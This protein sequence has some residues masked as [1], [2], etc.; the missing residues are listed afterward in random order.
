MI[1]EPFVLTAGA[2]TVD[3]LVRDI[4]VCL[5]AAGAL[6][7]LCA[8]LRLPT[9]AA[10]LLAGVAIGPVGL[11]IVTDQARIETI[12]R[13]GLVLLLFVIGVEVDLRMFA[14][15]GRAILISGLLQVPLTVAA[16]WGAFLGLRALGVP[17]LAGG[18]APLY[19]ALAC[20]FSSTLLVFQLLHARKQLDAGSSQLAIALL[21]FQ[22]AWAIVVLAV[23][24][25][26][27]R[28]DLLPILGTFAGIFLLVVAA[29]GASKWVLPPLF[30]LVAKVP[31][32][33]VLTALSWCFA[34]GLF[35]TNLDPLLSLVG[36]HA[37]LSV[38]LE[39]AALIAGAS[40]GGLPYAHEIVGK[41]ISLRDFFVTL[42]F[43]AIGM[44]IPLPRAPEVIGLAC[45]L[46]VIAVALRALVFLPVLHLAGVDRRRAVITATRLAQLSE[47]C[48]VILYLGR[49]LGHVDGDLV[50]VV[51]L[52]FV[53][54]ALATQP[55]FG[56]AERIEPAL[57]P[58]LSRL[59]MPAPNES[60]DTPM[61]WAPTRLLLLGF[62]RLSS[63]II[64]DLERNNPD[65]LSATAV[66]D[67]NVALHDALAA[68]G[69]HVVYG[70]V[71][72]LETLEHA[73]A[74]D[75]DVIVCTVPDDLLKGTSNV[76]LAATLRRIAPHARIL[77]NALT[78]RDAAAMYAAGADWVFA[79][80]VEAA[81]GVIPAI[82][83][84][85][86]GELED[87]RATR[88]EEGGD[89]AYREEIL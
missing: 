84:C 49:G 18:H 40:I 55:L 71:S 52:A 2:A 20:G 89:I 32:L 79:F 74:R 11:S 51:I 29:F 64:H 43:V 13:L 58:V 62:H 9:I 80:R 17:L 60:R 81:R 24:P 66:V 65:L 83:A 72:S 42:F 57:G 25:N 45:A 48:L 27:Q 44:S 41:V 78:R 12:A 19:L 39:L 8:R 75:A 59:G 21:V 56:V 53:L 73:G 16:A 6:S 23:Q 77:V 28:P 3:P 34:L 15:S 70:D 61:V 85:L 88:R 67:L 86:E 38:S 46:A 36:V 5:L 33:V 69:V 1:T 22:D 14:R 63:A 54:T 68:T 4:G 37:R 7:L 87:F 30:R 82:E 76:A 47:F 10:L 31:E 50:A 35:A 26:L